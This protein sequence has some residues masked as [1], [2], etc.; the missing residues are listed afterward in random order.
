MKIELSPIP[1]AYTLNSN[2]LLTRTY[3]NKLF[4][5]SGTIKQI[6]FKEIKILSDCFSKIIVNLI[7]DA[8]T[9]DMNEY[10]IQ[11]YMSDDY[12]TKRIDVYLTK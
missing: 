11:C 8:S 7:V 6:V 12:L 9:E 4:V 5:I 10:R 2:I 1:Q 3:V